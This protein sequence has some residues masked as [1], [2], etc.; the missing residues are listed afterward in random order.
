MF[1]AEIKLRKEVMQFTDEK[2]GKEVQF[3]GIRVVLAPT[4]GK[5]ITL[6][7]M[8]T[9][10]G[11]RAEL[12]QQLNPNLYHWYKSSSAGAEIYLKEIS[13]TQ[14]SPIQEIYSNSENQL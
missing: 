6:E 5:Y 1:N 13:N 14:K 4:V 8:T 7:N 3:G 10:I 9:G 12:L 2:T 11:D